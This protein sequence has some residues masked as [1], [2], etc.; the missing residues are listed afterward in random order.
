[1]KLLAKKLTDTAKLPEKGRS[2][3]EGWDIFADENI[4]LKE[5]RVTKV[6][7]G[8]A[9]AV[10]SEFLSWDGNKTNEKHYWLQIEGRSGL[11]FKGIQ[12]FGGI[13][14]NGYTGEIGVML[15]NLS[16][17]AY[18][19]AKGDK[20]AQL[21][22]RKHIESEVQEVDSLEESDRGDKGFGSSGK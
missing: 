3:D 15:A 16:G 6:S 20:I 5:G 4:V 10:E 1:M 2:E 11:A 22:I 8:I 13:V 21:V 19:V 9:C 12:P 7:T 17:G 18:T 14:D